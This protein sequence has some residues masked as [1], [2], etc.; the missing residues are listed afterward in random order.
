MK[1]SIKYIWSLALLALMSVS[2]F[3][4]TSCSDSDSAGGSQRL[5]V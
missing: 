2:Q 4:L 3:A 5:Q 1:H